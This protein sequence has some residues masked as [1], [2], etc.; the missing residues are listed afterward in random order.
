MGDERVS[1]LQPEPVWR[2]CHTWAELRAGAQPS[3]PGAVGQVRE[4]GGVEMSSALADYGWS[5]KGMGCNVSL[6][7]L[8]HG[9]NPNSI[10]TVLFA[11]D[12]IF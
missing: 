1:G 10:P 2:D 11:L 8:Q 5:R 4:K 7:L 3:Y 12:R 6:V 9:S